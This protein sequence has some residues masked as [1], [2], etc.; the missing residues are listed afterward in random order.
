MSRKQRR[1]RLRTKAIR[2]RDNIPLP[3]RSEWTMQ[4][5]QHV[6]DWIE[7]HSAHAIMLYLSMRSEVETYR[8]IDYLLTHARIVLAPVTDMKECTLTPHSVTNPRTELVR[9]RYGM[10]ELNP[11][12]CP[13]FPLD[14]ID[15]ILVP[16]AAFDPKGYRI[17][18]GGGFYDRFLPKCPQAKWI[19]LAY[20]AQIIEDTFPEVWD[21]PL[22][23]IFTENGCVILENDS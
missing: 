14:Q 8:L 20:E 1:K 19:G 7:T 18:Y 5:T 17:G 4:I 16:G 9:H 23:Q 15:L 12:I 21:V 11:K 2:R 22:H 3:V 10:R 6:I 13:A